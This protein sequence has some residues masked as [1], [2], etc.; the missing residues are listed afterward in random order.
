[1]AAL[2]WKYDG[3]MTS[4]GGFSLEYI[5]LVEWQVHVRRHG[6]IIFNGISL[7]PLCIHHPRIP[8]LVSASDCGSCLRHSSSS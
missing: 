4:C 7:L 1:V 5:Q 8:P 2:L 3:S 6:L